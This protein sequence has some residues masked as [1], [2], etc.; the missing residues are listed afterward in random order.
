MSEPIL[1]SQLR[2]FRWWRAVLGMVAFLAV[3][4]I[5]ARLVVV[6]TSRLVR[7]PLLLF[8]ECALLSVATVGLAASIDPRS[9]GLFAFFRRVLAGLA[10]L[11][12]LALAVMIVAGARPISAVLL[13]QAVILTF[14]L[15][16]SAT[17]LA[18][19][20]LGG[21]PFLAQFVTIFVVG[22]LLGTMFY[23]NPVIERDISPAQRE[24]VIRTVL[25]T[26]PISVMS[27]SLLEFDMLRS[28]IMYDRISTIARWYRIPAP[29]WWRTTLGYLAVTG[30]LA[31]VAGLSNRFRPVFRGGVR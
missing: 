22:A 17:F 29:V 11:A 1:L 4:S 28:R 14:C 6:H 7:T 12:V 2:S 5:V 15:L 21:E 31:A 20:C 25:A 16:V 10:V 19:R 30:I 13:S 27:Y 8:V 9:A 3:Y 26:N 24:R 23:A 18:V